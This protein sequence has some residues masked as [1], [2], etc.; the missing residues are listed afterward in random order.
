MIVLNPEIMLMK[1][2]CVEVYNTDSH[3]NRVFSPLSITP[4]DSFSSA[5]LSACYKSLLDYN[6]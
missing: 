3:F 6:H 1:S 2:T 5:D 4:V